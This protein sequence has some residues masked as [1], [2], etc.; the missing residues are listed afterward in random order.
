MEKLQRRAV[1]ERFLSQI[2]RPVKE[3]AVLVA[4]RQGPEEPKILIKSTLLLCVLHR[5]TLM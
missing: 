4:L 1:K 3:G 2:G 5:I